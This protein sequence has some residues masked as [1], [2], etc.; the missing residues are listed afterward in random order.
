MASIQ[1]YKPANEA[2]QQ[3][4][5]KASSNQSSSLGQKVSEMASFLKGGGH[6]MHGQPHTTTTTECY[7]QTVTYKTSENQ[8]LGGPK[9]RVG[10]TTDAVVVCDGKTKKTR[11]NRHT[12]DRDSRNLFQ[13]IKDGISGDSSCS[14]SES[15][16]DHE[17]NRKHKVISDRVI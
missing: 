14:D 2:C 5:H 10:C 13:K 16:S 4:C 17:G 7:S 12:K 1:C 6:R 3:K 9:H 15:D 11:G 8:G